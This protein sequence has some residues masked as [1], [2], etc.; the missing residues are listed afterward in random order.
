M[1]E[2]YL[3]YLYEKV[4]NESQL[5]DEQTADHKFKNK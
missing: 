2:K 3:N 1:K 5:I 4:I